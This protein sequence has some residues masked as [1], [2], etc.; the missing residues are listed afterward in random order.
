MVY[1]YIEVKEMFF[2]FFIRKKI[3]NKDNDKRI[4]DTYQM[5]SL[6]YKFTSSNPS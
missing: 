4:A 1:L 6:P 2:F 3:L 5:V